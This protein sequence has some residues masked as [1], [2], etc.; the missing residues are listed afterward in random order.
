MQLLFNTFSLLL[1]LPDMLIRS[2]EVTLKTLETG[3]QLIARRLQ[4]PFSFFQSLDAPQQL[5]LL[6]PFGPDRLHRETVEHR[7]HQQHRYAQQMPGRQRASLCDPLIEDDAI[8]DR[9][10]QR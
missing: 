5:C 8:P 3:L 6:L 2:R 1:L 4:R 10:Q 7:H 9:E